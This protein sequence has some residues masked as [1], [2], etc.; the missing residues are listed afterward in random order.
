M[1]NT[2]KGRKGDWGKERKI[3]IHREKER[4]RER[5]P[6]KVCVC[7]CVCTRVDKIRRIDRVTLARKKILNI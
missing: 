3:E 5:Y 2:G 6:E 4:E 1:N 7:V